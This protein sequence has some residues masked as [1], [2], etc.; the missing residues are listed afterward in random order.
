MEQSSSKRQW[1]VDRL[2]KINATDIISTP[3]AIESQMNGV[4][5]NRERW[6]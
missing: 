2:L 3:T 4:N 6:R 1:S 5:N